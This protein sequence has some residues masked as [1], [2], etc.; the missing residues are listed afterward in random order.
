LKNLSPIATRQFIDKADHFLQGM[1]LLNLDVPSY[2][3]G[4]GLLAVHSAISLNDAIVVGLTGKRRSS[5]DHAKAA[6]DLDKLCSSNKIADKKGI[7]HFKWL[8]AQKN[9]VAYKMDR[10]DDALVKMAV[11]KTERFNAWAY[12]YFEEILRAPNRA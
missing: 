7:S 8:L 10:L 9:L 4:I 3:T 2:R 11:D 5:Q 12:N 1:K 6:L